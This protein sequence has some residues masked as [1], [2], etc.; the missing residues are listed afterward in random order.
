VMETEDVEGFL[1]TV[2]AVS[3]QL[4]FAGD[5]CMW[6]MDKKNQEKPKKL[7]RETPKEMFDWCKDTEEDYQKGYYN[8]MLAAQDEVVPH[9]DAIVELTGHEMW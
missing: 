5:W 6:N 1:K 8:A 4:R 9:I 7:R 3:K 2:Y